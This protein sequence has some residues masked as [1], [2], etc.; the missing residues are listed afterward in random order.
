MLEPLVV[1]EGSLRDEDMLEARRYVSGL[2]DKEGIDTSRLDQILTQAS[3]VPAFA[4]EFFDEAD[5]FIND[6]LAQ[7]GLWFGHHPHDPACVGIFKEEEED[8]SVKTENAKAKIVAALSSGPMTRAEIAEQTGLDPTKVSAVIQGINKVAPDTFIKDPSRPDKGQKA[9][10]M[11]NDGSEAPEAPEKAEE[12]FADLQT[13]EAPKAPERAS[14]PMQ[15]TVEA[16]ISDVDKF[17]ALV[18]FKNPALAEELKEA[19][20]VF[21]TLH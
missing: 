8:M 10:W 12:V 15:A 19:V 1:S 18:V 4:G 16:N 6:E 9:R 2:L 11:L 21:K 17:V 3:D 14:Q 20:K 7:A 5:A 13:T